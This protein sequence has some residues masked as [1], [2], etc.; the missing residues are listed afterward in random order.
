MLGELGVI[1]FKWISDRSRIGTL[2]S[3][4][5]QGPFGSDGFLCGF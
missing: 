5:E 2:L 3:D 4:L 1:W